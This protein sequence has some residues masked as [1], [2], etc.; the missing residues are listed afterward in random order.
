MEDAVKTAGDMAP[1]NATVLLS[2]A[3]TSWDMYENYKARGEHF[4]QIVKNLREGSS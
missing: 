4:K 1:P 2:P 3:C